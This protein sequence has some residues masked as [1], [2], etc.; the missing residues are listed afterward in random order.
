M[1]ALRRG[2]RVA[3]ILGAWVALGRSVG[4]GTRRATRSEMRRASQRTPAEEMMEGGKVR[5]RPCRWVQIGPQ[6]AGLHA[7]RPAGEHAAV[8][9]NIRLTSTE[10][11]DVGILSSGVAWQQASHYLDNQA[12]QPL[13][14]A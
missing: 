2:E 8:V 7:T 9:T 10:V 1:T 13:K 11:A 12:W 4:G 3:A 6:R 14:K 5:K